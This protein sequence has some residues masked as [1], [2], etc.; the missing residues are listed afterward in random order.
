MA[1]QSRWVVKT[2]HG[3]QTNFG[4]VTGCGDCVRACTRNVSFVMVD[5]AMLP[6]G[7]KALL[8]PP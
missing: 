4:D 1:R 7:I 6:R 2:E 8:D 3:D 5:A